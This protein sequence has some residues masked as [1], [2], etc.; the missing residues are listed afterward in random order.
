[1][2]D[3][4][5]VVSGGTYGAGRAIV[6][7]LLA[8]GFDVCTFS[9][10]IDQVKAL[11][12]EVGDVEGRCLVEE[13]DVRDAA[14]LQDVLDAAVSRFG[15]VRVLVNNAAIRRTGNVMATTEEVWDEVLDVNLKGQ[16]LLSKVAVPTMVEAG[17]G[18]I[19]NMA[20]ISAYGGGSHVAYV[21]S[22][23][24]VIG[25][26]KA[27]AADLAKYRI[28]V[29]ALVPGFILSGMSEGVAQAWPQL[30]EMV[31]HTNVQGAVAMPEDYA[32]VV[33]FLVSEA[34]ALM[35]GAVIDVGFIPGIFP[36]DA[37]LFPANA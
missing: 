28:R 32:R 25:L 8:E 18:A 11:R 35:T 27:M 4:L 34:A 9:N 19:V 2:A 22:K 37:A 36:D 14:A 16:F 20:S 31:R 17:G 29:N 5:A 21:T 33:C 26:T 6:R 15:P 10:D 24:G 30:L 3:G 12:A 1:M 7:D 13:A 23:A